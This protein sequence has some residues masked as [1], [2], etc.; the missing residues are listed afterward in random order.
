MA[1]FYLKA[2]AHLTAHFSFCESNTRLF[3]KIDTKI[4]AR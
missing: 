2:N 1:S 3:W 4:Q